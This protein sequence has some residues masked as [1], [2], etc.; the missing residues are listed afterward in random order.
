MLFFFLSLFHAPLVGGEILGACIYIPDR[1][2]QNTQINHCWKEGICVFFFECMESSTYV[3]NTANMYL[4]PEILG[5]FVQL[6]SN[7]KPSYIS[8]QSVISFTNPKLCV[9]PFVDA[10]LSIRNPCA[11]SAETQARSSWARA[12]VRAAASPPRGIQPTPAEWLLLLLPPLVLR[13][14]TTGD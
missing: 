12:E 6:I 11:C 10:F 7:S 8:G 3:H 14:A 1:H 2:K 4:W 9:S 13:L 5:S